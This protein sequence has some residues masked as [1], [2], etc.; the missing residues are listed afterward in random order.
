MNYGI[1]LFTA[2]ATEPI[3]L[4]E[5]KKQVEVSEFVDV[6]DEHLRRLITSARQL[7]EDR[8]NRQLITATWDLKLDRFPVWSGDS[9]NKLT[10]EPIRIPRCPVQSVVITYSDSAGATQTLS[11]SV[12]KLIATREPAEVWLK[13]GQIWPIALFEPDVVNVRFVAGYG[14]LATTVPQKFK[15]AMLLMI[16]DWFENRMG[17]GE[18]SE[19]AERLIEACGYGDEFTQY[20]AP[21]YASR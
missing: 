5:A 15:Q 16:S 12:Y 10:P 19:T 4:P 11:T 17:E 18:V 13:F 7:F 20:G 21:F 2:P 6:H 3:S 9:Q 14:A 1:S 8:T